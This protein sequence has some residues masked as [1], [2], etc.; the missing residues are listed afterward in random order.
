MVYGLDQRVLVYGTE[1]MLSPIEVMDTS[2]NGCENMNT[3]NTIH[4]IST[5]TGGGGGRKR[6]GGATAINNNGNCT[7]SDMAGLTREERRS[8]YPWNPP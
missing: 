3:V 2:L 6:G 8:N 1:Q 7:S 5:T 4:Q